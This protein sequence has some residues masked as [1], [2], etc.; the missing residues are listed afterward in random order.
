MLFSLT[1]TDIPVIALLVFLEGILSIDNALVLALLVR[2]LPPEQ[3]KRALTYGLAGAVAFRILAI[4][5]AS[6]LMQMTWVKFVGGA[7]LLYLSYDYFSK[8]NASESNEQ[9]DFKP[10]SFWMTVVVVELTDM[11][12][13]ADSILTAV[14]LSKKL[15][16][17]LIGGICGLIMMRFVATLFIKLLKAYP[18]FESTAYV[19]IALV[20]IKL[21]L[22]GFHF[23]NID[24]HSSD[25]PASWIF[26]ISMLIAILF[27]F[28]KNKN[29]ASD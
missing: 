29:L 13:A 5:T 1:A 23:S 26:W 22:E 21:F 14:S 18:R 28:T 12:F 17:V 2:H 9:T 11:A 20:G 19:L 15:A 25:N 27:G 8:K 6:Y 7:Y 24:F 4:S 16:V 3:Y 10:R